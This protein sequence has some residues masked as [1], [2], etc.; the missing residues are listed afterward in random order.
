MGG[1]NIGN[2]WEYFEK[3]PCVIDMYIICEYIMEHWTI[4]Y[5]WNLCKN[6]Y[7]IFPIYRYK[8]IGISGET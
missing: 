7:F 8:P 2:T 6:I 5:F 3:L 1:K 4:T